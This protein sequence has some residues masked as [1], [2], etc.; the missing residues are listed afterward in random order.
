MQRGSG[1]VACVSGKEETEGI[2]ERVPLILDFGF[3]ILD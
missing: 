1:E 2:D 3:R